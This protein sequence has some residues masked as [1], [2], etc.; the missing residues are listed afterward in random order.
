M[1]NDDGVATCVAKTVAAING[2]V[3]LRITADQLVGV[4]VRL[5]N[6]QP[7]VIGNIQIQH[8]NNTGFTFTGMSNGAGRD[9]LGDVGCMT[10]DDC[11]SELCH[12]DHACGCKRP[13]DCVSGL[14][15]LL[16]N[17]CG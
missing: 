3:S 5:F 1:H 17:R 15:N 8:S 11:K 14:C 6:D 12:P 13:D 16:T 9:C 7:G 10:N 4:G 2:D